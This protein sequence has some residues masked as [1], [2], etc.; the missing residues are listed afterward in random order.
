MMLSVADTAFGRALGQ[1]MILFTRRPLCIEQLHLS[2]AALT[3]LAAQEHPEMAWPLEVR[4]E[5]GKSYLLTVEGILS[6]ESQTHAR[7]PIVAESTITEALDAWHGTQVKA[8][9]TDERMGTGFQL[10]LLKQS[11]PKAQA[12]LGIMCQW[13]LAQEKPCS[14][15]DNEG[16]AVECLASLKGAR[17]L[18][19]QLQPGGILTLT[20]NNASV[21]RICPADIVISSDYFLLL[22]NETYY[23]F[24]GQFV[25]SK[26]DD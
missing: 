11:H 24:A 15:E 10:R 18:S 21:L 6:K 5:D 20:F 7:M 14:S 23:R 19:S 12:E 17:L 9:L 3:D 8:V 1:F 16:W 22:E 25:V 2:Y 26:Q 13:T 4:E